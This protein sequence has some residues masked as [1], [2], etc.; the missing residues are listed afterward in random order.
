M[1]DG[2]Y[3]KLGII[4]DKSSTNEANQGIQG[5]TDYLGKLNKEV[6]QTSTSLDEL[7]RKSKA[8]GAGIA[9]SISGP[10]DWNLSTTSQGKM[11]AYGLGMHIPHTPAW[12]GR[13]SMWR[14]FMGTLRDIDG[15]LASNTKGA[16]AFAAGIGSMTHNLAIFGETLV[17]L[18]KSTC[19]IEVLDVPGLQAYPVEQCFDPGCNRR[20]GL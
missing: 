16:A 2:Q 4:F 14:P 11:A 10:V 13:V 8:I 1:A 7:T 15:L 5:V 12:M 18:A 6:R 19:Q 20:L 17:G 3:I 9:H